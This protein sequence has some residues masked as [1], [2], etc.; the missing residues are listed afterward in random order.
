MSE[1][2]PPRRSRRP[3]QSPSQRALGLLVR[4]EHSRLELARKLVA[5]GVAADEAQSAVQHMVREGWQDDRRFAEMLVRS[6]AG[7]GH[8]PLR[9]RAEL[10]THGLDA[11][12]IAGAME[13][14][15]LDWAESARRQV[16]RRFGLE[17]LQSLEQRRKAAELLAR[18]GFDRASILRAIAYDFDE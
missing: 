4:R 14:H 18:R 12:L 11:E 7:Q 17:A 2:A 13:E 16:E 9:I 8:G 6:R 15:G 1:D 10:Q 5:R 3:P